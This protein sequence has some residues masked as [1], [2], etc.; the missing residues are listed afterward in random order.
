MLSLEFFYCIFWISG[1][2]IVWFYTDWFVYYTQLFGIAQNTR[3]EYAKYLKTHK[4]K[5]FPDF[6]Y[7]K[8]FKTENR[9]LKF[10]YKLLGCP[11]CIM[12]WFCV[13]GAILLNELLLIAPLYIL[14]LFIFLQIKK[15]I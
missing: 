5:Y 12:I 10:L 15:L 6:L 14:S 8:S 3:L 4:N 7:E 9:F 1:L 11:Y 2:S 13:I